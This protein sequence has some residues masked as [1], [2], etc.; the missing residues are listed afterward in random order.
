MVRSNSFGQL[1]DDDHSAAD[2][3]PLR[4]QAPG[5][6]ARGTYQSIPSSSTNTTTTSDTPA[7]TY[8]RSSL[9]I[10]SAASESP[11]PRSSSASPFARLFR[12]DVGRGARGL[13]QG[14]AVVAMGVLCLG[15]GVLIGRQGQTNPSG[16]GKGGGIDH[17]LAGEWS[18]QPSILGNAFSPQDVDALFT[19]Y[20]FTDAH[21]EPLYG[22]SLLSPLTHPLIHTCAHSRSSSSAQPRV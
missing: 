12:V 3:L 19:A 18:P 9:S 10:S 15:V 6:S 8:I 11:S 4:H 14:S 20:H 21:I 7:V 2:T 17:L 13:L 5:G 1:H 22:T 16:G